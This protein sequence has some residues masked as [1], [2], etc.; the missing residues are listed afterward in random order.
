VLRWNFGCDGLCFILL[1]KFGIFKKILFAREFTLNQTN[2][3]Y[4]FTLDNI[5]W[6]I[7]VPLGSCVLV[8]TIGRY[9]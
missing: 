7:I 4:Y 5:S 2:Q 6:D 1:V 3:K 8:H 9:L